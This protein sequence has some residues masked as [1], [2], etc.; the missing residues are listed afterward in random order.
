MGGRQTGRETFL[1]NKEVSHTSLL[2][3][4]DLV[5]LSWWTDISHIFSLI[6]RPRISHLIEKYVSY[7]FS[8]G[9]ISY[10][11]LNKQISFISLWS[12]GD[13]VHLSYIQK[14]L[15]YISLIKGDLAY[16]F[17]ISY[18]SLKIGRHHVSP[19]NNKLSH[20]SHLIGRDL[21]YLYLDKEIYHISVLTEISHVSFLN[22]E[23]S[24]IT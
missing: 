3:A 21:V 18:I 13:L 10:I 20:T 9:E 1:L 23:I 14:Y 19:L 15:T 17:H 24:Y 22:W 4:R 16:L 2:I 6:E 11:S 8:W 5:Y 12:G 7:L